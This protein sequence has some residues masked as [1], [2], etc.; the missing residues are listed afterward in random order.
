MRLI[1][2]LLSEDT[3]IIST[4]TGRQPDGLTAK[5]VLKGLSA[6]GNLK[7]IFISISVSVHL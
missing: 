2:S 6:L 4:Q 5:P 7:S 3:G 1:I